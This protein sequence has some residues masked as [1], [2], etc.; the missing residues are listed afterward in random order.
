MR[1][2]KFEQEIVKRISKGETIEQIANTLRCNESRISQSFKRVQRK[3][4][5]SKFK[6][7]GCQNGDSKNIN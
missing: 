7:G 4:S 1:L 5:E 3:L 6:Q 2:T